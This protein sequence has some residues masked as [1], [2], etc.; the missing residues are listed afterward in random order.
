MDIVTYSQQILDE[1]GWD[2]GDKTPAGTG[3]DTPGSGY[4]QI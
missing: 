1:F 2:M 3:V 4:S